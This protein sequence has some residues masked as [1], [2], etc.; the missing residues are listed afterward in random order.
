MLYRRVPIDRTHY[1]ES[2]RWAGG[3]VLLCSYVCTFSAVNTEHFVLDT[4][5]PVKLGLQ[6]PS[7][8]HVPRR[9][10]PDFRTCSLKMIHFVCLEL[11]HILVAEGL[12]KHPKIGA[13][14]EL[15]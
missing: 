14:I 3:T 10:F 4:S 13:S 15:V 2:G 7:H 11:C 1:A 9:P 5:P 8:L 6:C 12:T